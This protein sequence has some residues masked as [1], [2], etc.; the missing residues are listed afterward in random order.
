MIDVV[1]D[2]GQTKVINKG[3]ERPLAKREKKWLKDQELAPD[4]K[5]D[6]ICWPEQEEYYM[7]YMPQTDNIYIF[8][9]TYNELDKGN[10]D[11]IGLGASHEVEHAI[12]FRLDKDRQMAVGSAVAGLVEKDEEAKIIF[13]DFVKKLYARPGGDY[14]K[15]HQFGNSEVKI[16]KDGSKPGLKD[17]RWLRV[18]VDDTGKKENLYLGLVTT[19]LF[20]YM[21]MGNHP[22]LCEGETLDNISARELVETAQAFK[23]KIESDTKTH[24]AI[25]QGGNLG[26]SRAVSDMGRFIEFS[27]E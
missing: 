13:K 26:M 12:Y 5:I 17:G 23:V 11:M 6:V 14:L 18:E 19:E 4:L 24:E 27:N 25:K 2:D 20:S 10:T 16:E 15:K 1:V 21:E 9:G 3:I 7:A 8:G 22:E